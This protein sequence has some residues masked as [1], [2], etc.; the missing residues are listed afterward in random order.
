[1]DTDALIAVHQDEWD[2]LRH[3]VRQRRLDAGEIDE[4]VSLYQRTATQLSVVRSTSP[5]PQLTARLSVLLARARWRITGA[6]VP[7]WRHARDVLWND[8][9]AALWASRWSTALAAGILLV[10]ALVV[11]FWFGLDGQARA[12][13]LTEAQ[14]Q[15]LTGHHFVD[16]YHQGQAGGFA[17]NVWSNNA[18]IAVQS[19]VF[20]VTGF[21]PVWML[22]Q[23]GANV[24]LTGGVMAAHDGLGTFFVFILPHGLLELTSI[25]VGAGAGLRVFWSWVRPG[26]LP[27]LWSLARAARALVTVAIGLVPVLLVSGILEAFVT[28]SALPSALRLVIGVGA[29][30]LFLAFAYGRGRAA[31]RAGVSGDLSE[32]MIGDRVAVA[33]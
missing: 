2:R 17:A 30:L 3:L 25:C 13:V 20:G 12:S 31:H 26:P 15:A 22:L 29:W 11:G 9:P 27:R 1:M 21:W 33:A 10:S 8:L 28:P 23:N 5:D 16:Y 24:G 14:Q 7:L 19:V 32:D 6:R 4:L 18:W